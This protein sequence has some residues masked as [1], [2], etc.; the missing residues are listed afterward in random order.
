MGNLL[1][2]NAHVIDPSQKIDTVGDVLVVD[3]KIADFG[4][5]LSCS[6]DNIID[7][8]GLV[9]APGL[10]DLHVH[11]RDPGLEYKEDIISGCRA[12]AAGG[13]TTVCAMPNTKP[14]C[15]NAETVKYI[16]EKA[17]NA[18]AHVLP[19]G[20]VSVGENGEKLTDMQALKEAGCCAFSD[21][22]GYCRWYR[23]CCRLN[24]RQCR[25]FHRFDC[26]L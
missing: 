13:V 11:L 5:A 4:K 8:S 24:P 26:P 9:L 22:G 21:D 18:D 17:A 2:K 15:D 3:G 14:V 10:I 25:C 23:C 16:L 20:A 6:A 12:A 1:F 19:I 7:A